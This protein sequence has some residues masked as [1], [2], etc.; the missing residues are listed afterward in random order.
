MSALTNVLA[1]AFKPPAQPSHGVPGNWWPAGAVMAADFLQSRYVVNGLPVSQA[2]LIANVNSSGGHVT[3][4][5]GHLVFIAP[6]LP[7]I[8]N[9]S[10]LLVEEQR[11][12][13]AL[14]SNTFDTIPW[15]S[16]SGLATPVQ[17]VT[18]PDNIVNSAWTFTDN[19]GNEERLRQEFTAVNS[20]TYSLSIYIKKDSDET[21]F[22]SVFLHL[23]GMSQL[24]ALVH[25]NTKTGAG[26]HEVNN[27]DGTFNIRDAGIWW[28]VEL[29]V[30]NNASG[31][32]TL[33]L[34]IQPA[35]G[36]VFGLPNAAAQ[37][38]AVFFGCQIE[39]APF[40]TSYIA[41]GASTATRSADSVTFNDISWFD[42]SMGTFFL[43]FT[44]LHDDVGDFSIIETDDGSSNNSIV[45]LQENQTTA[46]L[47]ITGG[48]TAQDDLS[49]Q[50]LK[51]RVNN[52]IAFAWETDS[53]LSVSGVTDQSGAVIIAPTGITDIDIGFRVGGTN[54]MPA[55]LYDQIA[56]WSTRKPND[57]LIH[58]TKQ[59]FQPFL[60]DQIVGQTLW[61]DGADPAMITE[62][63]GD[64]SQWDDKSGSN[65]HHMQ[66]VGV[67]MPKTGVNTINGLNVINFDGG[68]HFL[69]ATIPTPIN[70][71]FIVAT[72]EAGAPEFSGIFNQAGQDVENIR[73]MDFGFEFRGNGTTNTDDFTHPDG[74]TRINGAVTVPPAITVNTPFI[75]SA[76]SPT[77]PTFVP[78]LSQDFMSRLWKGDIAEVITYDTELSN[79]DRILVENYLSDKW[80][81][82]LP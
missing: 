80:G 44:S 58:L 3:N 1:N 62:S 68:D 42:E 4:S 48:G 47:E 25:I 41:T 6:N 65:V 81:I 32:T 31:N 11:T 74:E 2:S 77:G 18:G 52:K 79:E 82:T 59:F 69:A 26:V 23:I 49:V 14:Q 50:Q 21:R 19:G 63:G 78:Q 40:A 7:R 54:R 28:L 39:V 45:L 10:G 53:I 33:R 24:K 76:V 35:R 56:F 22:S 29:N 27:T 72:K 66:A 71:I 38:S 75:I 34:D 70:M 5:D 20:V 17:N 36:T 67:A 55:A 9:G 37:G 51:A 60:P 15:N 64:V 61:L 73:M 43:E 46:H 57:F 16:V 30:T 12:N 8:G 13:I